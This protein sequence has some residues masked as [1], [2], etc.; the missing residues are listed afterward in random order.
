MEDRF[1]ETLD[2]CHD[3]D[4]DELR[5]LV[6]QLEGVIEEREEEEDK[7]NYCVNCGCEKEDYESM[8]CDEC[9]EEEQERLHEDID[10]EEQEEIHY[11][12]IGVSVNDTMDGL[13]ISV[14]GDTD[15][16]ETYRIK[17]NMTR[18]S[19]M[20]LYN[21]TKEVARRLTMYYYQTSANLPTLVQV[22]DMIKDELLK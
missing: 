14:I 2:M 19:K 15:I 18:Y 1:M 7:N 8:Y 5:N 13:E 17:M 10:E 6:A 22:E 11:E 4:I 12:K 3:L 16:L 9:F 21:I 20:D